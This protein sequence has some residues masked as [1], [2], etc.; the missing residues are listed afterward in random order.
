MLALVPACVIV[1]NLRNMW[2]V[3]LIVLVTSVVSAI[4]FYIKGRR[5]VPEKYRKGEGSNYAYGTLLKM[6]AAMTLS[7]FLSVAAGYAVVSF[8]GF[9]GG[10]DSVGL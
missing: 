9:G 8:I 3:A 5:A 2:G 10:L 6:S 1:W 4:V 7:G